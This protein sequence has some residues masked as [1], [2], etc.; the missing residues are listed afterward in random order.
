MDNSPCSRT[1]RHSQAWSFLSCVFY[2]H[3]LE[4][5]FPELLVG[6]CEGSAQWT[7]GATRC[8]DLFVQN[9]VLLETQVSCGSVRRCSGDTVTHHTRVQGRSHTR[10]SWRHFR[11][12][13]TKKENWL[14]VE[15]QKIMYRCL[16]NSE[17]NATQRNATQRNA[18]HIRN[19]VTT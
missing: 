12:T 3:L 11:K 14:K 8:D 7:I 18:T 5:S 17:R 6:D 15:P 13:S 10:N 16:R 19:K 4:L 9:T 1:T 2:E